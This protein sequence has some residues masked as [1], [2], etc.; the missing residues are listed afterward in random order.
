MAT[1]ETGGGDVEIDGGEAGLVSIQAS[2]DA[3]NTAAGET[4]GDVSVTGQLVGLFDDAVIDASGHS[5]GGDIRF[6]GGREGQDETIRNAEAIFIDEHAALIADALVEGDGGTVIAYADD[7]A[8]IYGSVS[9]KG[10][11][12]GGDGGFAE[13]SGRHSLV[14]AKTPDVT[15]AISAACSSI[16]IASALRMVSS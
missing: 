14:V 9:A 4:G 6:G 5:G 15:A 8:N 3:T 1:I 13:T 7:V 11:T 16:N 2:V 12:E 10:G